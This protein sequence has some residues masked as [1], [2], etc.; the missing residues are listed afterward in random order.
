MCDT[1]VLAGKKMVDQP[2]PQSPQEWPR[3][4]NNISKEAM[5]MHFLFLFPEHL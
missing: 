2:V 4:P 5:K 3:V 1:Q